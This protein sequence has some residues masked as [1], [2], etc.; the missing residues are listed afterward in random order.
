MHVQ[1]SDVVA[2]REKA[3]RKARGIVEG[4]VK[5]KAHD[6]SDLCCLLCNARLHSH[7]PLRQLATFITRKHSTQIGV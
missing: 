2:V 3:G 5:R 6:Q 1:F 4:K 7:L